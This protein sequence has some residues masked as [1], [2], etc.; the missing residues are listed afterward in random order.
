MVLRLMFDLFN[1]MYSTRIKKYYDNMEELLITELHILYAS[2]AVFI[3]S[4]ANLHFNEW[5]L[6]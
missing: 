1:F 4:F 6:L 2:S 5:K 3:T